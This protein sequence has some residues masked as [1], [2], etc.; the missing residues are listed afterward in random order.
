MRRWVLSRNERPLNGH[1]RKYLGQPKFLQRKYKNLITL[2][3]YISPVHRPL[4][5]SKSKWK[6]PRTS[7]INHDPCRGLCVRNVIAN[8]PPFVVQSSLFSEVLKKLQ[9]KNCLKMKSNFY[10]YTVFLT[11]WS[12]S[13][14]VPTCFTA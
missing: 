2:L 4:I 1:N 9:D 6:S 3:L 11:L 10:S 5:I 14:T 13:D 12:T 7:S 8:E